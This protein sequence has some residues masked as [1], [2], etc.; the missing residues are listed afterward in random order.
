[1]TIAVGSG[2]QSVWTLEVASRSSLFIEA[3]YCEEFDC[4]VVHAMLISAS[5]SFLD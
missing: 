2:R 5:M 4:R 1:M 3:V